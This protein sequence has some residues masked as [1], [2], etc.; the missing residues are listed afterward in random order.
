MAA[1]LRGMGLIARGRAEGLNCFGDSPRAFLG[2][3]LPGLG[4]MAGAVIEGIADGEGAAALAGLLVP[5]CALLG[6]PVLSYELARLW[7]REAF[8]HRYIVAYNWSRWLLLVLLMTVLVGLTMGRMGGFL[9][10]GGFRLGITVLAGYA[11]W[12]NW[13]VARHGLALTGGRAALL[14]AGVNTGTLLLIFL[15][16]LLAGHAP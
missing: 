14:V 8:W 13:F 11:L 5:L 2:S 9:G 16:S 1:I 15:P 4:F 7:G 3:L 6:P 12:L 10:Q